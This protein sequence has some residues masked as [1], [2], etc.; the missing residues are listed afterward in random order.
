MTGVENVV[1]ECPV[2]EV[3][4]YNLQ[5]VRLSEPKGGVYIEVK[6]GKATKVVK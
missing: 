2:G 1:V 3:E 4:Y 5:G 6:N